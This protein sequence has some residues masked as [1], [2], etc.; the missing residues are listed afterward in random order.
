MSTIVLFAGNL[1]TE[2]SDWTKLS[3]KYIYNIND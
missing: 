1:I 3:I 2:H